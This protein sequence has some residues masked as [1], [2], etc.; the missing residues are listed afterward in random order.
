M[1]N[2]PFMKKATGGEG[3]RD[4]GRERWDQHRSSGRYKVLLSSPFFENFPP[5]VVGFWFVLQF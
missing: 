4:G 2:E 1:P 3:R 5:S